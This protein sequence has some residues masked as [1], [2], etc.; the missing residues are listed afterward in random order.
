MPTKQKAQPAKEEKIQFGLKGHGVIRAF[1]KERYVKSGGKTYQITDHWFNVSQ[2][3]DKGNYTNKSMKILFKK[4]SETP[5]N[6]NDI[7]VKDS[8]F[9]LNGEG[10]CLKIALFIMD[11]DYLDAE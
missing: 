9:T 5:E 4:D 8:F 3:D 10:E 6:N 11:W 2:K 7:V 1:N